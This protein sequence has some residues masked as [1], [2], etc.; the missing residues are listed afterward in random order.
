L[1]NVTIF[2]H[3]ETPMNNVALHKEVW[4]ELYDP[5]F[6]DKYTIEKLD[7]STPSPLPFRFNDGGRS[8]AGFSG[9]A[10]DCVARSTAIASGLSYIEVYS[11]LAQGNATQRASKRTPRRTRTASQ[12]IFTQRKWF[13]DYMTSLGFVWVPTQRIGSVN[14]ARLCKGALP[15]GKLVVSVPRH[16]TAV[17]NGVINDTFDCSRNGK[18]CVYGYWVKRT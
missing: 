18:R 2:N 15:N 8:K 9:S 11:A 12:G 13:K 1:R 14:K 10:R 5:D 16:Y 3:R 6:P 17:I 7:A 4:P